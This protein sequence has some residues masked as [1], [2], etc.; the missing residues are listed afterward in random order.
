MNEPERRVCAR[1]VSHGSF[2]DYCHC[3]SCQNGVEW[4]ALHIRQLECV[5]GTHICSCCFFVEPCY[6]EPAAT[7]RGIRSRFCL[8]HPYCE[9][10]PT[11][12]AAQLDALEREHRAPPVT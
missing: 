8:R 3:D 5:D 7:R 11:L 4:Q 12:S 6:D 1:L 10:K 9:H 2:C